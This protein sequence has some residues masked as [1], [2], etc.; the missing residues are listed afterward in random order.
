MKFIR[1]QGSAD[2]I[3]AL[4]AEY[5]REFGAAV[6]VTHSVPPE[7][8]QDLLSTSAVIGLIPSEAGDCYMPGISERLDAAHP[9]ALKHLHQAV[10]QT[11]IV[12]RL[13]EGLFRLIRY[14]G[15]IG[16][17]LV[18]NFQVAAKSVERYREITGAY[19]QSVCEAGFG[20][21]C[22]GQILFCLLHGIRYSGVSAQPGGKSF[23]NWDELQKILQYLRTP[24]DVRSCVGSVVHN[25]DFAAQHAPGPYDL[26]YSHVVYEH[27]TDPR[28]F[29]E[30]IVRS[31]GPDGYFVCDV[32][33]TGHGYGD[34][35]LAFLKLSDAQ[36]GGGVNQVA[37]RMKYE[38]YLTMFADQGLEVVRA[39]RSM[40][41]DVPNDIVA[42]FPEYTLGYGM[43]EFACR[44]PATR[45]RTR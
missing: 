45:G 25:A 42:S 31:L 7:E 27:V 20:S 37:N 11:D 10:G 22:T 13:H 32:D 26:V 38:D 3:A 30:H 34:H 41:L 17:S 44:K 12:D 8:I 29:T 21:D 24:L 2:R 43:C 39:E 16:S 23:S 36:F 33:F 18:H 6:I 9:Q 28:G 14:S 15:Q 4:R 19:P 35:P 1:I 5:E 40:P